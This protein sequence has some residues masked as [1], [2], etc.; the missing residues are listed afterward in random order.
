MCYGRRQI[1]RDICIYLFDSG[2]RP[3]TRRIHPLWKVHCS[4]YQAP[5]CQL[6]NNP[7]THW[8]SWS[9]EWCDAAKR[10]GTRRAKHGQAW[11]P[12]VN[13]VSHWCI[14]SGT[15]VTPDIASGNGCN[16]S[17]L[18]QVSDHIACDISI[19]VGF[20]DLCKPARRIA[21]TFPF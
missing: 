14:D 7:K 6:R 1:G 11:P 18:L 12:W 19:F 5:I 9:R 3:A 17:G 4:G 16:Y 10:N 21:R 8:E 13:V 2:R 20:P 15:V